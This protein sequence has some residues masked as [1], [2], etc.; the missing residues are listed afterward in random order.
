MTVNI[1]FNYKF[2]TKDTYLRFMNQINRQLGG[3]SHEAALNKAIQVFQLTARPDARKVVVV[4]TDSFPTKVP[5]VVKKA[6]RGL[7]LDD[8]KVVPVPIGIDADETAMKTLSPYKG[9]LVKADKSNVP[10]E[11]AEKIMEIVIKG[12][13]LY[14]DLFYNLLEY[15]MNNLLK[16]F[17]KNIVKNDE[18][19][20]DSGTCERGDKKC[21]FECSLQHLTR[22]I[23]H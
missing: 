21:I 7:D 4:M 13:A 23:M 8:V 9:V 6:A 18:I 1:D 15:Y 11:L 16:Y 5:E 22:E 3:L 19:C 17:M 2:P 10:K 14:I 12:W 20:I